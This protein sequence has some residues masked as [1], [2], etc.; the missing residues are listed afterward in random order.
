MELRRLT[1]DCD[2][3]VSA[4]RQLGNNRLRF[5]GKFMDPTVFLL[6]ASGTAR[7]ERIRQPGAGGQVVTQQFCSMTTQPTGI[8]CGS[9]LHRVPEKFLP[10][11]RQ[12]L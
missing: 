12:K 8:S 11:V 5:S 7:R 6:H 9:L 3:R 4:L 10:S 2:R 1:A